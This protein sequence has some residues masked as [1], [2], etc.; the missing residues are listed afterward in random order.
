MIQILQYGQVKPEQ[1]FARVEPAVNVQ[2]IV[3]DI[4]ATV[5]KKGDQALLEYTERF[6]Q[7]RLSSLLVTQ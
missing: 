4:I 3:A 6:D 2:A 1:I 7:A 5:R